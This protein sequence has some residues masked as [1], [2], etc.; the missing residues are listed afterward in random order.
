[1][2]ASPITAVDLAQVSG[3]ASYPA[4]PSGAAFPAGGRV[5]GNEGVG[6]V[7]EASSGSGL[8]KGDVVAP[9]QGGQG[10]WAT[11]VIAAGAAW[12]KV[13][14]DVASLGAVETV[15]AGIAPTL[16][17]Q[18]LLGDFVKLQKGAFSRALFRARRRWHLLRAQGLHPPLP[19]LNL[20]SA[21]THTR[22]PPPPPPPPAR[23][24]GGGDVLGPPG[25]HAVVAR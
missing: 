5:C 19:T 14:A 2:L 3:S 1:M 25:G 12:T 16:V 6:I 4:A 13:A 10:T 7:L 15:A 23:G 21:H 8:K 22:P 20:R 24:G 18:H 17:A 9:S 11:H